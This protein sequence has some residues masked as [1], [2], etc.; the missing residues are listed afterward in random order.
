[1]PYRGFLPV[2]LPS[3]AVLASHSDPLVCGMPRIHLRGYRRHAGVNR[4][5]CWRAYAAYQQTAV[6]RAC[7]SAALLGG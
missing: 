7:R 1:M 2:A 3:R 5:S 6:P 4:K